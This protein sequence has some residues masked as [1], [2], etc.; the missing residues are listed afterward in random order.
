MDSGIRIPIITRIAEYPVVYLDLL[1]GYK[2]GT[3]RLKC[4]NDRMK[5]LTS[6]YRRCRQKSDKS[7]LILS[8]PFTVE[9]PAP[10]PPLLHI[11]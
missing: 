9:H 6:P 11:C 2:D 1:Y 7:Y 3:L 5:N 10:H 4:V 8:H